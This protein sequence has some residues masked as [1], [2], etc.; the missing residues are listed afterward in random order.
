MCSFIMNSTAEQWANVFDV[1]KREVLDTQSEPKLYVV[2][3]DQEQAIRTGLQ[4]SQMRDMLV[5]F[6]CAL[7]AKWNVRDHEY[8]STS[9]RGVCEE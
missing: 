4:M 6:F 7:H 9:K 8:V 2:T 3:S 5:Q 1:F